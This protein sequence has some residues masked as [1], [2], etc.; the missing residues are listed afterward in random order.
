[1]YIGVVIFFMLRVQENFLRKACLTGYQSGS[2]I[3]ESTGK[4]S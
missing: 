1:M 3:T 2:Q 4:L